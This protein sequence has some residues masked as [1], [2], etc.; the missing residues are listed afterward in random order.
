MRRRPRR[1]TLGAVAVAALVALGFAVQ[2]APRIRD[3]VT[4][5]TGHGVVRG[6][7]EVLRATDAIVVAR[8]EAIGSPRWN[9]A[10]GSSWEDEFLA[11]TKRFD[12]NPF[13][14]TQVEVLI[15]KVI[16]TAGETNL[17]AGQRVSI[18]VSGDPSLSRAEASRNLSF[19]SPRDGG[20]LEEGAARMLLLSRTRLGYKEGL[21][22]LTWHS[23][24][25][26]RIW[27]ISDEI[28]VP[29]TRE[30]QTELLQDMRAVRQGAGETRGLRLATLADMAQK[31]R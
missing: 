27:G 3:A 4:G 13:Q 15:Q 20:Y 9:S 14:I 12:V 24:P 5:N 28:A 29:A 18:D 23:F 17:S 1:F 25:E 10:D 31:S 6:I 21:G 2:Q 16:W 22:P 19:E 30:H 26:D 8:V 11:D 7:S